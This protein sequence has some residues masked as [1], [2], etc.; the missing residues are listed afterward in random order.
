MIPTNRGGICNDDCASFT[1]AVPNLLG[2]GCLDNVV[3]GHHDCQ[4]V[5]DGGCFGHPL[6]VVAED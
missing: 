5:L 3:R 2:F 1:L 4:N 6:S